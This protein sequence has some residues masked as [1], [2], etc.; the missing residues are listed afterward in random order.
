[1]FGTGSVRFSARS[2]L[3]R[4][5]ASAVL[6]LWCLLSLVSGTTPLLCLSLGEQCSPHAA[7]P[8]GSCHDQAPDSGMNSSCGSCVD[9]LI[10]EDASVSCSR[11]DREL[12][13]LTATQSLVAASAALIAM[14]DALATTSTHLILQSPLHPI[15]RSAVLRI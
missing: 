8:T 11:P 13:P 10:P 9:I 4:A 15:L 7:A 5:G 3:S 14:E 12:R 2:G 6:A 1:M